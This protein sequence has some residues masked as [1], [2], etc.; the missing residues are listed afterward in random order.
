MT[1]Y[2]EQL[3]VLQLLWG[4][5]STNSEL[6]L[7]HVQQDSIGLD[8][9]SDNE[10]VILQPGKVVV[11]STGIAATPPTGTYIR[12]APRSG[13]TVNKYLTTL[14]GVIVTSELFFL[15]LAMNPSL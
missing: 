3:R 2:H 10:D 8:L 11:I 12:I 14:A 9:F 5:A 4:T 7:G 13:L 6:V 1:S 15:T